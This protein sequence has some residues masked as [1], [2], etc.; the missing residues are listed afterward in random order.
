M[1]TGLKGARAMLRSWGVES[2]KV[3]RGLL[4]P[5]FGSS[6][7]RSDKLPYQPVVV[8]RTRMPK[9]CISYLV[10]LFSFTPSRK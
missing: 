5:M 1:G 3:A 8:L 7:T 2:R 10:C 4:F 6:R 9:P